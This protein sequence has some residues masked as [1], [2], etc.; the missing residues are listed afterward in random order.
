MALKLNGKNNRLQRSDFMQVAAIAGLAATRVGEE[1]DYFLQ[2]F[3]EAIEGVSV[4]DLPGMDR[5]IQERAE[6]M[7]ALCRERVT[8]FR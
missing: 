4:P 7:I 8:A 3:A 1:I 6:A 5:D 2:R